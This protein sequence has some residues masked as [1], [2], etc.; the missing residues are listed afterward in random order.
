MSEPKQPR[1]T[2]GTII[3]LTCFGG[4]V[5]LF[6]LFCSGLH[7][8]VISPQ[9]SLAK[10]IREDFKIELPTSLKVANAAR[11]AYR[12]PSYHYECDLPPAV[13]L[14]FMQQLEAAAKAAGYNY[15]LKDAKEADE[16]YTPLTRRFAS[17]SSPAWYDPAAL[18]DRQDLTISLGG[19]GYWFFFSPPTGKLYVYWYAT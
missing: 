16:F 5:L 1:F 6:I 10:G 9:A 7:F 17:G 15:E 4:I 2:K 12:D 8:P 3:T 19:R 18:P 13:L 14:T 11:H